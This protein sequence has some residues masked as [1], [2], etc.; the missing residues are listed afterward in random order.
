VRC[1]ATHTENWGK[2]DASQS[3]G[4]KAAT[5]VERQRMVSAD[6]SFLLGQRGSTASGGQVLLHDFRDLTFLKR[7]TAAGIFG[8]CMSSSGLVYAIT[9]N[10]GPAACGGLALQTLTAGFLLVVYLRTYVARLVL[11]PKRGRV[12]VTGC[13]FFG[14][15][16]QTDQEVPLMAI[17]P[18]PEVTD[19]Y[20]KFGIRGPMLD[21]LT[22]FWYR[23]PRAPEGEE[24]A[25]K[26]KKKGAQVG[27]TPEPTVVAAR[28]EQERLR[29]P[30]P[31][32]GGAGGRRFPGAGLGNE[33]LEDDGFGTGGPAVK[34]GKPVKRAVVDTSASRP[35]T[36]TL[37]N[38]KLLD[39]LPVDAREEQRLVE[40]LEDPMAY[41]TFQV[42][43]PGS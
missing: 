1:F 6:R 27:F 40:F 10:L 31:T 43:S 24:R 38:F 39:G 35:V 28:P 17:K 14:E 4:S 3:S 34:P 2:A 32:A 29:G 5:D 26:A 12:L 16:M 42:R 21:P 30:A 8:T 37:S 41:G 25:K 13:T 18:Q 7:L 20:I 15:A 22:W 9:L 36:K 23:I 11:D 33:D 19:P